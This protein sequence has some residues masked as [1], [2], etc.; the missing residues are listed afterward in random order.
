VLRSAP[1]RIEAG[2]Y[3]GKLVCRDYHVAE[4]S[5]HQ[6]RWIYRERGNGQARWFLHGLFG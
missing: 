1:E 2:W 4:G 5:D 3:D 6:L